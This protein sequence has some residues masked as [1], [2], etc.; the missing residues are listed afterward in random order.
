MVFGS[1]LSEF[2][3]VE[4]ED[5]EGNIFK[6][7]N[8]LLSKVGFKIIGIPHIGMRFRSKLIIDKIKNTNTKILDVGCGGGI[9][10]LTLLKLGY[11]VYAIDIDRKKI[12]FLKKSGIKTEVM[13]ICDLNFENN[14]FDTVICSEVL[15][16]V[17][18]YKKGFSEIV[19]VLKKNGKILFTSPYLSE[20]NKKNFKKY[21]HIVPGFSEE[22]IKRFT[23][24]NI[25]E[26]ILYASPI[27]EFAFKLNKK[28]YK[29]FILL[30]LFFYPLYLMALLEKIIRFKDNKYNGM[31]LILNRK[32]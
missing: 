10:P 2:K 11:E 6:I 8:N 18:D 25:E 21:K 27:L 32:I 30:G 15:E 29:N 19:R 22:D 9:L 23:G 14:S 4:L 26:R 5:A 31:F 20:Y 12:G 28:F 7:K 1:V 3:E 16:H 24:L 17:K 13:D